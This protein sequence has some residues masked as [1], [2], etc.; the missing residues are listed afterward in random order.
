MDSERGYFRN[1]SSQRLILY[2]VIL[3][4][5]I[6]AVILVFTL[7]LSGNESTPKPA[8]FVGRDVLKDVALVD[9]YN[10]LPVSL[11]YQL[12]GKIN[13][14][15]FNQDLSKDASLTWL[16]TDIPRLKQGMVGCQ[17]WTAKSR[18][19]SQLKD[20]VA[21]T[22]QQIDAITRLNRKFKDDMKIV[23][24]SEDINQIFKDGKIGSIL[25][26]DGGHSI[27]NKLSVLR[28]Y[29][30]LG[31]RYITLTSECNTPWSTSYTTDS[32]ND[33]TSFGEKVIEEMNRVGMIIDLYQSSEATQKKVLEKSK[34]PVIFSS[35]AT[36]YHKE[37]LP[38]IKNDV[39]DLI[40]K[41]NGLV[42]ITFN[43]DYMLKKKG[44][45]VT[46][47]NVVEQINYIRDKIGVDYIGIGSGFGTSSSAIQGLEDSS[48]FPAL[49]D[50]LAKPQNKE[51]KWVKEDLEKLA[52]LNFLRVFQ[53][54]EKVRDKNGNTIE[55]I[56][57]DDD[58]K[59]LDHRCYS[60]MK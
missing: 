38:N 44:D 37:V 58:L 48:K 18:C 27:D 34:A 30:A 3:V 22:I 13:D 21:S 25:S 50:R 57:P 35:V 9:G 43:P 7:L 11:W 24:N 1:V 32:K 47:E 49:F 2:G 53:E 46:I 12:S 15:K 10:N 59:T 41:N 36:W 42:M 14:F 51:P 8:E 54:V 31:V 16:K 4:S 45:T 17:I 28:T 29:Y 5:V 33:L 20:S 56:I 26:I 6:V 23:Y 19:T 55:D 39:L 60:D 52:G 40:K